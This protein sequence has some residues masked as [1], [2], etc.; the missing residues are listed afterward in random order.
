MHTG[1]DK[2]TFGRTRLS[3]ADERD[4][5]DFVTMLAKFESGEITPDEWRAFRLVRG[6]YGQRQ[7]YA[8]QMVRVTMLRN[9]IHAA[10]GTSRPARTSNCTS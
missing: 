8:S 7:A 2:D 6:T 9:A 10:S 1:Q 4:I 3:F 5:D